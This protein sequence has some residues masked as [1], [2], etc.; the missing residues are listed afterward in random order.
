MPVLQVRLPDG[1][2]Q[3]RRF[4]QS[5]PLEHIFDHIDVQQ[6]QRHQE[7]TAAAVASGGTSSSTGCIMPGSYSLVLQYPRRVIAAGQAGSLTDAGITSDTALL[8]EL[9]TKG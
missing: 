5:Q 3:A 7:A 9:N 8:V 2:R 1:T 6:L 4:R